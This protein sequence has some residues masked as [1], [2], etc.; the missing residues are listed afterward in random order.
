M[1]GLIRSTLVSLPKKV[2]S[3]KPGQSIAEPSSVS[4]FIT[5]KPNGALLPEPTKDSLGFLGVSGTVTV[6]LFLGAAISKNIASFL[7]ENELF[8]PTD[9]DDDD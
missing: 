1:S 5:T 9:D 4:R 6:G 7:E 3:L 8:V 2:I